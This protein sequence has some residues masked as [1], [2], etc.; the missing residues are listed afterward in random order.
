MV[1][2]MQMIH[3]TCGSMILDGIRNETI[4]EKARVAPVEDKIREAR[5]RWFGH[6][7]RRN[8]NALVRRCEHI[9]LMNYRRGR[10]GPKTVWNEVIRQ[11][12]NFIGLSED[13]AQ[14]E[15]CGGLGLRLHI[16]DGVVLV[17]YFH[18]WA[19]ACS[20]GYLSYIHLMISG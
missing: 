20:T 10:G 16:I 14:I 4:R 6:V 1:A 7:K 5:L 18:V 15:V 12:L 11:D 19:S 17:R 13:M 8:V 3:W 9:N 2:K